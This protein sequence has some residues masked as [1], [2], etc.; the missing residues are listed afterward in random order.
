MRER[1]GLFACEGEDLVSAA[2]DAGLTPADALVDPGRPALL[3]RLPSAEEVEPKLLAAISG[4]AHPPRVIAVFRTADLPRLDPGAAPPAGLALWHVGDPGNV[5]TLLRSA[6]ALGPASVCLSAG[7]ADPV[8]PKALRASAGAV[9]RVPL[10]SFDKAPR[11]WLAL[12]P[13]GGEPL[14]TVELPDRVTL[15]LGAERAGLPA[16]VVARCDAVATIPE[17]PGA[18]SINVGVAGSIA[19]YE[20]RRRRGGTLRE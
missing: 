12:V 7:C 17:A 20:W 5:G 4:L 9:F 19:L 15:V 18:A 3:D 1:L 11:P 14:E 10:G 6:G 8:S 16:D 2:L 13:S